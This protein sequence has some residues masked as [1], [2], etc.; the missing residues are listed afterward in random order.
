M[1][2]WPVVCIVAYAISKKRAL[3]LSRDSRRTPARCST[4]IFRHMWKASFDRSTSVP[5]GHVNGYRS[6]NGPA[7]AVDSRLV[8][9]QARQVSASAT[10]IARI[11]E[12]VAAGATA[13]L[14][15]MSTMLHDVAGMAT[16]LKDT[17]HQAT[18]VA[19]AT[20]VA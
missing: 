10:L 6:G 20:A 17:A 5:A 11:T 12:D 1:Y 7:P 4:E 13:Q 14:D 8:I 2:P 3:I 16:S 15:S 18:A 9:D 19:T